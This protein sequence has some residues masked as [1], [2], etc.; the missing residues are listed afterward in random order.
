MTTLRTAYP[1]AYIFCAVGP[2]LSGASLTAAQGAI[3]DVITMRHAAGDAKVA[4]VQFPTQD[5]L[6]DGSGCGCDYHPSAATHQAM[7]TLLEAAIQSAL[8]W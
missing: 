4:L 1:G 8:S 5:C 6:A 7:A 3:N 2:L